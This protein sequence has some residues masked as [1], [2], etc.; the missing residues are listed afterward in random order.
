[1]DDPRYSPVV[2]DDR[3]IVKIMPGEPA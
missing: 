1:V 2:V 3:A